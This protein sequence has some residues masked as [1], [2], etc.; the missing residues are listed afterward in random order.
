LNLN[1]EK[2]WY[3]F[4]NIFER[5]IGYKKTTHKYSRDHMIFWTSGKIGSK[6][7]VMDSWKEMNK[8]PSVIFND[9]KIVFEKNVGFPVP[10]GLNCWMWG[11]IFYIPKSKFKGF[12]AISSILN[13]HNVFLEFAV[14]II[15]YGLA[16]H[17]DI[18]V[19][20]GKYLWY[21]ERQFA[22]TVFVENVKHF[23]HAIK[24]SDILDN[25]NY[26]TFFCSKVFSQLIYAIK[27]PIPF[28]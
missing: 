26:K 22:H 4:H 13:K 18:E 14:P 15:L 28:F 10:V 20:D 12:E 5:C 19:L 27:E 3:P 21:A 1:K 25:L 8:T 17:N 7:A 9:W 24:V 11:D 6:T 23:L 2:I 16:S